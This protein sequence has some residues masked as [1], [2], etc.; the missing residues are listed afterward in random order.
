MARHKFVELQNGLDLAR[1]AWS[2]R[3]SGRDGT[4]HHRDFSADH[5]RRLSAPVGLG[6]GVEAVAWCPLRRSGPASGHLLNAHA[7]DLTGRRDVSDSGLMAQVF[8]LSPPEP[9]KPRLRW[10]GDD[11]DLNVKAMRTGLLQFSQGC[12]MAIRNPM[13]H[14]T[15]ENVEQKALEQ[16]A[17][18]S[19]LARWIE[20]WELVEA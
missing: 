20:E 8:S 19:M 7:H 15:D 16:L 14:S 10:P 5:G 6:C 4:L 11:S 12:F 1:R 3:D 18:L 13:T 2:P 17:V 9:G